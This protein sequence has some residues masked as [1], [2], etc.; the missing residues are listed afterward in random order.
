MNISFNPSSLYGTIDYKKELAAMKR[1]MAKLPR[2]RETALKVL[3]AT[4]MHSPKTGKLKKRF[5]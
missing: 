2:N 5:R 1:A 3:A 4:G